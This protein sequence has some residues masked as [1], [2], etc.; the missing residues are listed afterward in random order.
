MRNKR[1]VKL[2][3]VV[4][5]NRLEYKGSEAF[6]HSAVP[7]LLN[8]MDT[9]RVSKL[10]NAAATLRTLAVDSAKAIEE[11]EATTAALE[12]Q[13][14]EMDETTQLMQRLQ[15]YL[16]TYTRSF[17]VLSGILQRIGTTADSIAQSLE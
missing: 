4:G 8:Q 5:A 13:V 15:R 9:L 1:T 12:N 7:G 10:T 3:I 16:D 14:D 11:L 2:K 17:E 6:L